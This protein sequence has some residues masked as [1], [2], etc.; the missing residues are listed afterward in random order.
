MSAGQAPAHGVAHC[1]PVGLP[2][3]SNSVFVQLAPH[4]PSSASESHTFPVY[5]TPQAS[6][7]E[8]DDQDRMMSP[9]AAGATTLAV[10]AYRPSVVGALGSKPELLARRAARGLEAA[11]SDSCVCQVSFRVPVFESVR[12]ALS[13][14]PV[15]ALNAR[16]VGSTAARA[17]GRLKACWMTCPTVD[18]S[19][20]ADRVP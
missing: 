2:K 3:G 11:P 9:G 20:L 5:P 15:P 12:V 17:V 13:V 7:I 19:T 8:D 4:E 1:R 6:G 16:D 14:W 10:R 18:T